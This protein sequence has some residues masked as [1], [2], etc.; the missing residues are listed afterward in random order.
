MSGYTDDRL[1]DHEMGGAGPELLCKPFSVE[2][3]TARVHAVLAEPA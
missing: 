2:T 1:A 3:L